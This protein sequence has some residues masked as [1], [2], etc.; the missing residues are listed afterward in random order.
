MRR[1][2]LYSTVALLVL[3][4]LHP[5][6]SSAQLADVQPIKPLMMLLVDTSGSMEY[7]PDTVT[8]VDALPNCSYNST[9]DRNQK[10]RWAITV[11]ALTGTLT[12]FKCQLEPRTGFDKNYHIPHYSFAGVSSEDGVL[13]AFKDRLK[14][15]LMTFDGVLTTVGGRALEPFSS[16]VDD[17]NY[18]SKISGSPGMWSYPVS[19]MEGSDK[20]GWK[21]L[22]YPA[23]PVPYGVNAGARGEGT[24]PGSL[25]G[26]GAS[27]NGT[28]VRAVNDKI[29]AAL[30]KVRPYGGTPIA[31]MLDDFRYYLEESKD[32]RPGKVADGNDPY[33]K[34]RKRYAVL[35]T[36]GAPDALFRNEKDYGCEK[37]TSSPNGVCDGV[38]CCPY[39]PEEIITEN[40]RS[41]DRLD[42]LWVVAFNVNDQV[43]IAKLNKIAEKG[44]TEQAIQVLSASTLRST[45]SRLMSEAGPEA[46]S[47]SVPVV[48]NTGRA[49][50]LG[51]KQYEISAGFRVG[52]FD[53]PW[54]GFLY[55]RRLT[56]N[57]T[58]PKTQ[59]LDPKQGD[60]FHEVLNATDGAKR[61]IYTLA[62]AVDTSKTPSSAVQ[63]SLYASLPAAVT[64]P[65]LGGTKIN[66]RRGKDGEP[67]DVGPS[68][69]VATKAT[70]DAQNKAELGFGQKLSDSPFGATFSKLYFGDA[71]GDKLIGTD[72]D[73][74]WIYNFTRGIAPSGSSGW[75]DR[76]KKKL[77]DIYHSNP[78][79][80]LPIVQGSDTLN[81]FDPLLRSLY[82]KM[83]AA[84]DSDISGLAMHT[85]GRYGTAGR[86]GVVFVGSNDG[87]LHAFSLDDYNGD[88]LK[89]TAGQEMWGF[90]P[91]SLF[92]KMHAAAAPT[93]QLMFDGTP[94]VKDVI[95][96]RVVTT[97]DSNAFMGT[98]LLAA[99]GGASSYVA[100]DVTFP[101]DPRFL[102]QR[103][104]PFL[105]T[106]VATPTIGHVKIKWG[107]G[108]QMRAVA[109]LPGGEGVQSDT[110]KGCAV[111]VNSRGKAPDGRDQVR[112]WNM[113]GRSLYVIDML[114]GE[115]I[116]E[117][118][119]RHFPAPLN[120]SIAA[121][122][123]DEPL[124][125]TRAAYMTDA[126]GV[127]FRL[128][129][130]T[131]DPTRWRVQPIWDLFAGKARLLSDEISMEVDAG[132]P[133]W[134]A[135]HVSENAPVLSRD[136]YG[137]LTIIVG[138]GD[139]DNLIDTVPNRVVSL[140]ETRVLDSKTGDLLTGTKVEANW[141]IQL[142]NGEGVTGPLSVF[143]ETLYFASFEATADPSDMCQ[144]GR[145]R[146]VGVHVR[147]ADGGLP[148]PKLLSEDEK[149]LVHYY[150]P[151][152]ESTRTSLLLGLSITQDPVCVDIKSVVND[153]LLGLP[154]RVNGTTGGGQFRMR[155]MVAGGGGGAVM[156]GSASTGFAGLRQLQRTL[157]IRNEAQSVGWASSI[158]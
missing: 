74:D 56:C 86:P 147:E 32:V 10:N 110:T 3:S 94:V 20:F 42:K 55:R 82:T 2:K 152:D 121:D 115:V 150:Y 63:G 122:S 5:T 46:T 125:Q 31:A 145:T 131:E 14:F 127:L 30:S 4:A 111:D 140:K 119:A 104:F 117:F 43:G 57:G 52:M 81:N 126:D 28:N 26:V 151:S 1:N 99:V 136:R 83:W 118:D 60:M 134:S 149:R 120:G 34:C 50:M 95:Y 71:N 8:S 70:Q 129:M 21:Q 138:T 142:K 103:S 35:L 154:M 36:D 58:E 53:A 24:E 132:S 22:Y 9:N 91:P 13:D 102:W 59:A 62:P 78:V 124:S 96:K 66:V 73:R 17:P 76:S 106:T 69:E 39:D 105:G 85:K 90:I 135:G 84:K 41:Q 47:R 64:E 19:G 156:E 139:A 38:D 11:E 72:A 114:T 15:G 51:G 144:I 92:S 155:S 33:F 97:A 16:Y 153:P 146:I 128:W 158:E 77:G 130:G 18:P 113:Q 141:R 101:E 93:H 75:A 88:G 23:C 65:A 61:A 44:G 143:D 25:V 67:F 27:D 116:Q 29:Q 109:I 157:P 112:C 54:D 87:I 68:T 107:G 79:V 45:M 108:V 6:R 48:I 148:K 40:L 80:M 37:I 49:V 133:L 98:V 123:D 7:L 12:D 89:L 137:N 100:I